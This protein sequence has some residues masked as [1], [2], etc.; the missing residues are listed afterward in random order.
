MPTVLAIN[1]WLS[2]N[3]IVSRIIILIYYKLIPYFILQLSENI[4]HE[5]IQKSVSLYLTK[6][7]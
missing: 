7:N 2:S 6:R 4:F 3:K 5:C 1:A